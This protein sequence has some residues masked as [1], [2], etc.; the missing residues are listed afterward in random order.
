VNKVILDKTRI[1]FYNDR[2][3][4][5]FSMA[6]NKHENGY[7][8]GY[9][10]GAYLQASDFYD[11]TMCEDEIKRIT[12]SD[13]CFLTK[14][15]AIVKAKIVLDHCIR[16][17]YPNFW[18]VVL[19]IRDWMVLPHEL[20][21]WQRCYGACCSDWGLKSMRLTKAMKDVYGVDSPFRKR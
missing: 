11:W 5:E 21:V 19:P 8:I 18:V 16:D 17:G 10:C 2:R 6:R 1:A 13:N 7:R 9:S 4:E 12:K 20:N 3:K 14:K 15:E